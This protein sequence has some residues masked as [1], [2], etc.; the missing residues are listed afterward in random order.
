VLTKLSEFIPSDPPYPVIAL[1][2]TRL[3]SLCEFLDPL[4]P[5]QLI[6]MQQP[7]QVVGVSY[8]FSI[9]SF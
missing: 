9:Y 8:P 6:Q 2:Q 3:C 1:K 7:G 4:Q 5:G